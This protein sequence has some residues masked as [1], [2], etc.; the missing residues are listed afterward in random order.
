MINYKINSH[1]IYY[2]QSHLNMSTPFEGVKCFLK[3]FCS[4]YRIG[5]L[6]NPFYLGTFFL[7]LAEIF[8]KFSDMKEEIKFILFL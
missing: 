7:T 2:V 4:F 5:L 6:K 3:S 1:L 8:R